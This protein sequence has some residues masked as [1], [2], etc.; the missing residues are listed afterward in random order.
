MSIQELE[1]KIEELRHNIHAEY[2]RG[3]IRDEAKIADLQQQLDDLTQQ[4]DVEQRLEQHKE[5]VEESTKEIEFIMDNLQHEGVSMRQLC[6]D[7]GAYQLLRAVV[8]QEFMNRDQKFLTEIKDLKAQLDT[9][10]AD[11]AKV[12][13]TYDELYEES[14]QQRMIN[15]QLQNE[16]N[17]LKLQ[18]EDAEQKRDAAAN[19]LAESK[20]ENERLNGHIDDLRKQIAVGASSA[21]QVIDVKGAYEQ[22]IQNKKQADAEKPAIYDVQQVDLKGSEFTAKLAATDEEIK[23]K[24]TEKGKYKE[25]TAQ[26]A[27]VFRAEYEAKKAAEQAQR[28]NE[29]LARDSGAVVVPTDSQFQNDSETQLNGL[30]QGDVD[31]TME[32]EATGSVEE[33]IQALEKRVAVLEQ[34]NGILAAS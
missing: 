15:M 33:R 24:W 26:E 29:D 34:N 12:Q 16:I 30:D 1:Q 21:A 8:Q 27:E 17:N 23:F 31:G 25:V 13:Q 4:L 19:E 9:E 2:Q 6:E 18:I 5:R 3:A 11:K 20:A 22:Y 14:A 32:T 10:K 7:E 28:D